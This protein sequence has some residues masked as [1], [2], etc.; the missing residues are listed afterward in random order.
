[1]AAIKA[2]PAIQAALAATSLPEAGRASLRDT[3]IRFYLH[4]I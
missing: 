2:K 1:M 4:I 3:F